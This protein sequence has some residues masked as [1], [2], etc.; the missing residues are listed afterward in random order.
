MRTLWRVLKYLHKYKGQLVIAYIAL[1]IGVG[2][3]LV[4]PKLVEYIIDEGISGDNN[5]VVVWGATAIVLAAIAQGLFTYTRSYLFQSLSERVA[6]DM[7]LEYYRKL[8]TLT[9]SYYD[10]AQ[11]GQLM[12]RG[13]EDINSIRRFM[14]FSM[15]MLVLSITMTIAVIIILFR[16]NAELA[17]I[18]LLVLPLLIFS[19]YR[20][21]RIIRP[22]FLAIQ[23]Q[24]GEMSSVMQ[25][26]LA[27]TRVVRVFAQERRE[28]QKFDESLEQLF[29]KQMDAVSIWSKY[30]PAMTTLNELSIA[31]VLWFGGRQVIS[32]DI[33]IGTLIA[34]NLYL[35]M[36]AQPV[37]SLGFIV[38]SMA[39]AIASGDRI[40]EVLDTKPA[41]KDKADAVS[42]DRPKGKVDFVDVSFT[43]PGSDDPVLENITFDVEPNKVVAL[44]GPTGSGKSSV[45]SL[46]PRFYEVSKG[47]VLIDGV[48]V[49]D[50]DLRSLRKSVAFVLQDTFLFSFSIRDNIAFGNEDASEEQIERA[51]KI[52]RAHDFIMETPDGYDTILGERGVS[53]SGGQKQRI[54]IARAICA[55][56]R[57][58]IL[59][60]ATSSVD[61]ETEFLIQQALRDAMVGRTT[62]V[63]AQ[64]LSTLKDADEIIVLDQGRIVQQ[65]T[66]AQ[67]VNEEGLYAR[68][69]DLQLKDQEEMVQQVAD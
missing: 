64:R 41:I 44:F 66:H 38:N 46:V 61:T 20:F 37:R 27:G 6:T 47:E 55:D 8:Q 40:F 29:D 68:I 22:R 50:V 1:F 18:S 56:P 35:A 42:L 26:N 57:I 65:G 45:T 43:Y 11:S 16:T 28:I 69:Y 31:F 15:R 60:D 3:M 33:S 24:F 58:L 53:L 59:D 19:A 5:S 2:A 63:I 34:F 62:F 32:G 30:F 48:D 23:Q 39:R 67:L 10:H 36:L 9:F 14:M 7:R 4:V 17:A 51:A 52:A 21:G 25:E 13:A 54:A 12:S 49:R